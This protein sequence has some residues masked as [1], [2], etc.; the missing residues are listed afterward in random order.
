[1]K[2]P[3]RDATSAASAARSASL[4]V[5]TADLREPYDVLGPLFTYVT[6]R[7]GMLTDLGKKL[8]V[9]RSRFVTPNDF[10]HVESPRGDVLKHTVLTKAFHVCLEMLKR[11][12]AGQG[13]DAI[14]GLRHELTL[15]PGSPFFV[16][17]MSGTAV[18]RRG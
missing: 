6:D 3:S 14:V 8:D 10:G 9:S 13:G 1:M 2:N 16:L 18:K 11:T 4:T 15:E 12:C 5:T 17:T 7:D